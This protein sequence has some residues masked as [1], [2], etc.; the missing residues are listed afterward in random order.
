MTE[1]NQSI[2]NVQAAL[3]AGK[4]LGAPDR[5]GSSQDFV[6][7][8]KDYRIEALEKHVEAFADIPRR[9]KATPSLHNAESFIDYVGLFKTP[10]SQVFA[11]IPP[12]NA[13][14]S[15]LAVIDY[16]ESGKPRWGEH[17]A[18]YDCQFTEEWKRWLGSDKKRMSQ[19]DFATLLEENQG[20][21]T[22]PPGAELLELI[23][24][25]EGKN[26][27]TCNSLVRLTN[28]RQK[29]FYEE[30]V[31]LKGTISTQQNQVEF[32]SQLT[33]VIAPFD[34]GPGY[35]IVCRLRYRIESRRLIFWYECIDVHLVIKECVQ[36]VVDRIQE[37]LAV[38]VLFGT[39]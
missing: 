3:D 25:L 17:R 4:A 2:S 14:P 36:G 27:I 32:P 39:P 19:V 8:P 33:V 38:K 30:N 21:I 26:D 34:G 12:G 11:I 13:A 7:V 29:L 5:P 9:T 18:K 35:R 24:T 6:V 15:F 16:H 20:S 31:E 1:N 23:Q 28:G 37:K 22:A 10:A